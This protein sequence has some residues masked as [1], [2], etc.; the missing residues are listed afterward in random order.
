MSSDALDGLS[1]WYGSEINNGAENY[2]SLFGE[3]G[4]G[5]TLEEEGK[6]KKQ[7]RFAL[8]R[9]GFKLWKGF[10]GV[11]IRFK[12]PKCIESEIHDHYPDVQYVGFKSGA[13]GGDPSDTEETKGEQEDEHVFS[14]HCS[15]PEEETSKEDSDNDEVM[16]CNKAGSVVAVW[17]NG[18]VT[19]VSECGNNNS[20]D[21]SSDDEKPANPPPLPLEQVPMRL[22]RAY[23]R[24]KKY[25]VHSPIAPK[26]FKKN[27]NDKEL[28]KPMAG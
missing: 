15:Q 6:D 28:A 3:Q 8:Y 20:S 26:K 23:K 1:Q 13:K 24:L 4:V 18:N 10:T 19:E 12:L 5:P 22:E 17:K 16:I 7:I 27:N 21:D 25:S 14:Q 9:E 2:D 11:G